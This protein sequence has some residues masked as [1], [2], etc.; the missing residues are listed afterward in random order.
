M[1]TADDFLGPVNLG[2]P[3]EFTILELAQKV[4]SLTDSKSEIVFKVL[5]ND[6]PLQRK[7]DITLARNNLGWEPLIKLE[8]GLIKTIQYFSGL[9]R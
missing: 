3:V 2:N 8:D 9:M 1:A 4:V 6:D 5:P 7:P